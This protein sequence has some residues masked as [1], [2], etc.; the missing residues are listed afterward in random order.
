MGF[1]LRSA[2]WLGLV[3]HA[4]PWGEARLADVVPTAREAIAAG[5]ATQSRDGGEAAT[6]AGAILRATF[7]S[8]PAIAGKAA[9]RFDRSLKTAR[10]SVDTLSPADRVPPW[11]GAG[12]RP[13]L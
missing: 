2:F 4:M 1:F 11:R 8:R 7:E 6:V 9:A 13:T 12:L 10:A 5:L 3:F